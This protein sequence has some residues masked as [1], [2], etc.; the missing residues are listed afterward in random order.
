[1]H[2]FN[3]EKLMIWLR[4]TIDGLCTLYA[5]IKYEIVLGIADNE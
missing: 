2:E 3:H 4:K 5:I 1:M